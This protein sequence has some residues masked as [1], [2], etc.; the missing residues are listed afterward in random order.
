MRKLIFIIGLFISTTS[1]GQTKEFVQK[2]TAFKNQS[3]KWGYMN[4]K[5]KAVVISPTYDDAHGFSFG[6]AAVKNNDK[7]FYIDKAGSSICNEK[8]D[9]AGDFDEYGE[10]IVS[11]DGKW[12]KL[13]YN[14]FLYHN[15]QLMRAS[16]LGEDIYKEEYLRQ[17]KLGWSLQEYDGSAEMI[18]GIEKSFTPAATREELFANKTKKYYHANGKLSA[19]GNE[20]NGKK[21]GEWKFYSTD[22]ILIETS[23]WKDNVAHGRYVYYYNRA[24]VIKQSGSL[25]QGKNNGLIAFYN[26]NNARLTHTELWENGVL[27]KIK[28]IYDVNGNLVSS[29]GT[30]TLIYYNNDSQQIAGKIEYQNGHRSGTNIQY[31]GNGKIKLRALYKY[32]PNDPFGLRWEIIEVNDFNGT[33]LEKGT[34]KNGNGTW[35]SYHDNGKPNLITTYQNGKKVKEETALVKGIDN[36]YNNIVK[37]NKTGNTGNPFAEMALS[38]QPYEQI[39]VKAELKSQNYGRAFQCAKSGD[40]KGIVFCTA[41]LGLLYHD[42]LGTEKDLSKAFQY[43][44]K[45]AELGSPE[46]M[47]YLGLMYHDGEHVQKNVST[48]FV[49]FKKSADQ[50]IPEANYLMSRAYYFGFPEA[51]VA[52]NY[53]TALDYAIKAK[54][55]YQNTPEFTNHLAYCYFSSGNKKMAYGILSALVKSHPNYANGFDSLGEVCEAIGLSSEAIKNYVKAAQMGIENAQK[56]CKAKQIKY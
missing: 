17:E 49:W 44:K 33:P 5:T 38:N 45:A 32:T 18:D 13:Y 42:G 36:I 28:D 10:A 2:L 30:G 50:K 52:I 56:W 54:E 55:A 9:K 51:G 31:H 26:P 23:N 20:I 7:W 37:D 25:N 43:Y 27:K 21:Q 12:G 11:I 1:F 4:S 6:Y 22:G 39:C 24:N 48:A 8:F 35:I 14:S 29:T 40:E 53:K 47:Y 34:L 46:A 19:E 41:V 15:C 16:N 3:G